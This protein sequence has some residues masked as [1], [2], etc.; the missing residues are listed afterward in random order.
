MPGKPEYADKYYDM[1]QGSAGKI[2]NQRGPWNQ[3]AQWEYV[4]D[5]E[6]QGAVDGSDGAGTVELPQA[7]AEILDKAAM[8]TKSKTDSDP[9][10]GVELGAGPGAGKTKDSS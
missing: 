9:T 4:E 8:R 2:T 7:D 3:G 6:Q 1:S 5:R 10:T